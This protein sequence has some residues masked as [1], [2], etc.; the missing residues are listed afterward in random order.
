MK[1]ACWIALAATMLAAPTARAAGEDVICR[2]GDFPTEQ[3]TFGLA[4]VQGPSRLSFLAD[5]DGCPS[6]AASCRQKA[7]VVAGNV[8]LT[9]RSHGRYVCAFFPNRFSGSAGWVP[10]D[11]LTP[12]AV[13]RAPP[14][15]AWLGHWKNGDD[16]I[17]LTVKGEALTVDG[18]AYWPSAHP[19]PADAP[20]GPNEGN[21]AG[22][23]RPTGNRVEIGDPQSCLAS[24]ALVGD[25]LVVADN[26][27]CGGMNV[28]FTGVYRR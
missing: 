5:A 16:T 11:R 20:G 2:N 3:T 26:N 28:S 9:G 4:R 25:L 13:V 8:L 12:I 17:D 21:L 7:Y 24:L 23:A 19:S 15:S 18:E 14:L 10:A 1:K 27:A 6:E 22:Q